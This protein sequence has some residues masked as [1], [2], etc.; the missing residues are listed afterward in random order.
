[1]INLATLLS[2]WLISGAKARERFAKITTNIFYASPK[3]FL[4]ELVQNKDDNAKKTSA[5]RYV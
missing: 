3:Y 5:L 4:V 2:E 1:M